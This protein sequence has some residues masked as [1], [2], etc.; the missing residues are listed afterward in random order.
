MILDC[1]WKF[2]VLKRIESFNYDEFI[3]YLV[4]FNL[5]FSGFSTVLLAEDAVTHK[6]Y[7]IK[8]IICHGLED[9]RLAA[10]EIEY[11]NLV[12]HPN[13]IECIDSTYKGTADP[14]INATSEALI[15]LPYYHVSFVL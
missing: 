2:F 14:I 7:A 9:Q 3:F 13:V 4:E 10:K 5:N 11:H 6:K 12:K 8:K 15:V 1:T